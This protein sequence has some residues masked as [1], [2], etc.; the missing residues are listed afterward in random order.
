MATAAQHRQ[1]L[2]RLSPEEGMV[3]LHKQSN[4]CS[5]RQARQELVPA[6]AGG[7]NRWQPAALLD[8][9]LNKMTVGA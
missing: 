5:P 9:T 3:R 4:E 8:S 7:M 6:A 2:P 1:D